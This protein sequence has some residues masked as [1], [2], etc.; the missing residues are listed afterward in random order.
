VD[1]AALGSAIEQLKEFLGGCEC[2][3]EVLGLA[4]KKCGLSVE[5]A[6]CMVIDEA[7]VA[8]LQAEVDRD[9]EID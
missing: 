7:G 6:I 8:E 5:D 2:S 3:D 1:Q 4:L 9:T